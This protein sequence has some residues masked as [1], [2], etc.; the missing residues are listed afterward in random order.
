MDIREEN[1]KIVEKF[2]GYL[3]SPLPSGSDLV[4]M[5]NMF[6]D[7]AVWEMPFMP[8]PLEKAI[9]GRALI[10]HFLDWFFAAVPD[11]RISDRVVHPTLDPNLFVIEFK[12]NATV[13]MT[14]KPYN[15]TYILNMQIRDGKLALLREHF[16][17]MVVWESFGGYDG[18]LEGGAK[19]QE[20]AAA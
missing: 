17:S 13:T 14:G 1:K 6:S 10:G 16:D 2:F 19:I 18:L 12:A 5:K 15:Q 7:D 8:A 11:M 4:E 9:P 20:A 3:Q